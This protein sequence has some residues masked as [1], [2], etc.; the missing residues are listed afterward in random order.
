MGTVIERAT[1]EEYERNFDC[2]EVRDKYV[3]PDQGSINPDIG[4]YESNCDTV[5]AF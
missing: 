4:E 2:L 3:I 5:K 1:N